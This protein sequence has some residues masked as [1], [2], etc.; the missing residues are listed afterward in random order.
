MTKKLVVPLSAETDAEFQLMLEDLAR[1][2]KGWAVA[3]VE[4]DI[5]SSGAKIGVITVKKESKTKLLVF[6]LSTKSAVEFDLF[7]EEWESLKPRWRLV[8]VD[9][10]IDSGVPVAQF[11]IERI[12]EDVAGTTVARGVTAATKSVQKTRSPAKKTTGTQRPSIP[13][14]NRNH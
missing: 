6:P 12:Q 2:P 3:D 5:E 13:A 4:S 9:R 8:G 1:L 11:T 14:L 7:I 10:A